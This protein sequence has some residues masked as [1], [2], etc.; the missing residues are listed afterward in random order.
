MK[1][2]IKNRILEKASA[3][4]FE[5]RGIIG[6]VDP[7]S[8]REFNMWYNDEAITVFSIDEVMN[9][10]L[11]NGNSLAEIADDLEEIDGL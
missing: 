5:Y 4:T 2:I 1:D 11:F 9:K 10:K 8:S 7:I 3:V 6:G